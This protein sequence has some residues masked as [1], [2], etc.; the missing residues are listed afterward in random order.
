MEGHM[1]RLILALL[2]VG[3]A[4]L[5]H[6]Q[7]PVTVVNIQAVDY[8]HDAALSLGTTSGPL[9]MCRTS[10]ARPTVA[11]GDTRAFAIW[12]NQYGAIHTIATDNAGNPATNVT[13]YFLT[14]AASTNSTNV[15]N[16]AGSVY[17]IH[18][19]NTTGT[20][21]YLRLYNLSAAPTC[22]SATGFI[23]SIPILGTSPN[24]RA[25]SVGMTFGTGIG[26]CLTGGGSSTD[27]TNAATGVYISL[28]YL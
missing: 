25:L 1:K 9:G 15:K 6:A 12:C 2:C 16:A 18:V 28:G 17:Y 5:A 3:W 26:F 21:Y 11:T 10:A 20:T 4:S 24:G 14:S 19:T 7:Q 8:T 13:P 27:N 22:S 23:E